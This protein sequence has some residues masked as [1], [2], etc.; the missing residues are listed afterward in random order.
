MGTYRLS[1]AYLKADSGGDG[2]ILVNSTTKNGTSDNTWITVTSDEFTSDGVASTKLG[3]RAQHTNS[4]NKIYAVD[5]FKLEWNLTKSL[6]TLLDAANTFYDAE[7]S[8]YT[9][10]K[11]AIDAADAVKESDNASTLETQY[12]AL[13]AALDLAKNHRK[14]WLVAKTTAQKAIDN[15]TD[16]GNVVGVEKTNLDTEIAKAEPSTADDYDAAKSSLKDA[17]TAFTGAKTNYDNL[18]TEIVKAKTLGIDDDTADGYAASSSSTS[19]SVLASTQALKVAEYTYVTTNYTEALTLAEGDWTASKIKDES[20][21]PWDESTA[22]KTSNGYDNSSWNCSYSQTFDL[23]AGDYIFMVAGRRSSSAAMWIEVKN[24]DTPLGTTANDFPK[25]SSGLGINT[26]GATDFTKGEGHTYANSGDGYGWEWR[27]VKFSLAEKTTVTVA[28]K[29]SAGVSSQ[30]INFSGYQ[31]L[32]TS[33]LHVSLYDYFKALNTA[34]AARDNATYTNVDGKEKADLLAAI[35]ADEGLDK[36]SKTD[37]DAAETAL[38]EATTAFTDEDAVTK[39]DA[40]AI[41]ISNA[42]AIVDAGKN[43]GEGVFQIPAS[44]Q[45]A[46]NTAISTATSIKTN[47]AKTKTDA[48]SATTAMNGAV[49]TYNAA[50]LNAPDPSKTYYIKVATS[51]HAKN[52]NAIAVNLGEITVNNPTGY[53]FSAPSAPA[54]YSRLQAFTLVKGTGNNYTISINGPD[55]VVYLTNGTKTG[56]SAEWKASQIQ[57]TSDLETAM[58]FKIATSPNNGAFVIYNTETNSTIACQSGGSIYTESG[59]A[60]FSI[61]EVAEASVPI[62]IAAD[63]KFATRIFPFTPSLP[64]GVKAYSCSAVDDDNSE[65]L[66][67]EEVD[68]PAANIPYILYAENGYSGADLTGYGTAIKDCYDEGW[69][70]GVYTSRAAT[71]GTYVLQNQSGTI[72]FYKVEDVKPTVGEYRCYLT[73][74]GGGARALHFDF[75]ETTAVETIQALTAGKNTIYNVAG[76]VVPSLQKGLNIIKTSDGKIRKV[77]VK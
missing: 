74:P 18:V 37:V 12:N 47:H 64:S 10:L 62:T 76:K 16:Y 46:L 71:E 51:G 28:I 23:P 50:E 45:S 57:A 11:T 77:I 35:N 22:Y 13:S 30:W 29:G 3:Y 34:I 56:S 75:D 48:E 17:T 68:E 41:A 19:A 49:E 1:A 67:L 8:S 26:S 39:Y 40:L 70:T 27:Y 73:V 7:G 14:P 33:D 66:K 58:E 53:T 6:Q 60:D 72:A 25:A 4:Y 32:A 5:N 55:G 65:Y 15:T 59:N 31:V 2:Y 44:A 38:S 42:Q 21:C 54:A 63:V 24:G 20:T 43:V 52:G 61:Q 69:L 36:T 9:A